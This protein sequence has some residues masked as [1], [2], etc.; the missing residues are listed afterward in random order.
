[1]TRNWREPDSTWTENFGVCDSSPPSHFP[2]S[3]AGREASSGGRAS[4]VTEGVGWVIFH[5]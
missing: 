5:T 4:S 2:K 3:R 1:M